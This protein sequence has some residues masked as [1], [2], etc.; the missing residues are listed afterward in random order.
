ML[1]NHQG[2]LLHFFSP[3]EYVYVCVPTYVCAGACSGKAR[4]GIGSLGTQITDGYGLP[5]GCWELN[6]GPLQQQ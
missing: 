6:L 4:G 2:N 1:G 3:K 5:C